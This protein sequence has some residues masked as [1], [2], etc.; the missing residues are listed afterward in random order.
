LEV[1][2]PPENVTAK[3]NKL[4]S[5]LHLGELVTSYACDR[6]FEPDPSSVAAEVVG[7]GVSNIPYHHERFEHWDRTVR[8]VYDDGIKYVW[9]SNG[10]TGCF[11]VREA[12]ANVETETTCRRLPE[13]YDVALFSNPIDEFAESARSES[14]TVSIDDGTRDRLADLGYM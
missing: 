2:N 13:S 1:I 8:C 7:I 9:D 10:D 12:P 4:F 14:Q 5:H 6:Q 11:Q 3:T